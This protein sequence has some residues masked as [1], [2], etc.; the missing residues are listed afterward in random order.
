MAAV[1]IPNILPIK[2]DILP[3]GA[4]NISFI[5]PNCLSQITDMPKNILVNRRV[6]AIIPGNKNWV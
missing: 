5:K 2:I 1:P 3:I 4:T 6:W